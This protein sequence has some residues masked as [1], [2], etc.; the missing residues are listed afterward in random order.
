VLECYAALRARGL[1]NTTCSLAHGVLHAALEDAA[2]WDLV[3]R[4][5]T[6]RVKAPKRST[7]EMQTLTA[8]ETGRLLLAA[9]GDPLEA[10]YVVALTTGL[11]LGELQAL[12]WQDVDLMRRRLMVRRTLT[13]IRD[14][15]PVFGEPKTK[16]SR[17]MV[18][19]TE[20]A[21]AALERHRVD[22][23]AR[24]RLA[25]VAW[26]EHGPVFTNARGNPLDGNN[27]RV[28]YF[29]PLLERQAC[30]RCASTT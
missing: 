10:F 18:S 22:Q 2:D 4:N 13:A 29:K 1:S 25:D 30:R 21:I 11:R 26:T 5:V 7:P 15:M 6:D 23:D 28:R 9:Q 12:R 17:R 20:V 24:R 8:E 3:E 16:N 14:G 19:L 27:V